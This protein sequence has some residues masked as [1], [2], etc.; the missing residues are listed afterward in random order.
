MTDEQV[1]RRFQRLIPRRAPVADARG[2][3]IA[4]DIH[5][6]DEQDEQIGEPLI[7][8]WSIIGAREVELLERMGRRTVSVVPFPRVAL[9]GCA[10]ALADDLPCSVV[11]HT[12]APAD[13]AA[14]SEWMNGV[15]QVCDVLVTCA[16]L[17]GPVG[18]VL[19]TEGLL[20]PGGVARI[21]QRPVL[22]LPAEPDAGARA[23]LAAALR[24]M[25][26]LPLA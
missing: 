24:S 11:A 10:R 7:E 12:P 2:H 19:R 14:V 1:L 17:D 13:A 15:A 3:A 25:A 4:E 8:A 23:L 6:G 26:A 18:E 20:Q 5:A 22:A 9:L 16:P 21:A